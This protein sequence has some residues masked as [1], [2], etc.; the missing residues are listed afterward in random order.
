MAEARRRGDRVVVVTATAGEHGTSDPRR[1][2]PRRLAARRRRELRA[3]LAVL[4]VTEHHLLG[5]PDG[6]CRRV[7]GTSRIAELI[8]EVRPDTIVTFGP[9]GMTGHPDHRAVSAWTTAAWR[10]AESDAAL[11]YAT[12]TSGFHRAWRAVNDRVGLWADIDQPPC[13]DPADLVHAVELHGA[14]LDQK[15]AALSAHASQTAPLVALLGPATY[16]QWWSTEAFVDAAHQPA[17]AGVV[18]PAHLGATP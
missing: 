8:L 4:G 18:G 7:D 5:H 12:V 10:A 6:G 1:W 13:A 2:P 11:W 9:D 3:S 15:V 17:A 16:R 14:R